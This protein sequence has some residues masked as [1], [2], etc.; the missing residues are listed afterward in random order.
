MSRITLRRGARRAALVLSILLP[1]APAVARK[2]RAA[3]LGAEGGAPTA[4]DCGGEAAFDSA[5]AGANGKVAFLR[6]GFDGGDGVY[7]MNAD[8]S[9]QLR[10]TADGEAPT[11]S[12]DGT[13]IAFTIY[14]GPGNGFGEIYVV[15]ADGC[16]PVNVTKHPLPDLSPTWS[17]D[18]AKIA[19]ITNRDHSNPQDPEDGLNE[20]YVMNA[21]GSNQTRITN[22]QGGF[23]LTPAWSPD[24][25]KIAFGFAPPN[26]RSDTEVEIYVI[27]ADSTNLTRLTNNTLSD[28]EPSWSPDSQK[29]AFERATG[30]AGSQ[31][32]YV[33]NADGTSQTRLTNNSD[34]DL[35]P[36]WSPDG[37]KIAFVG[38]RNSNFDIYVMNAGGTNP[39]RLTS[40]PG[41]DIQP[42]WQTLPSS[43]EPT[44]TP[45]P[46]TA[47]TGYVTLTFDELPTQPAKCVHIG[48]VSFDYQTNA[49]ASLNALY[50]SFTATT[51]F[52]QDRALEVDPTGTLTLNFDVPTSFLRFGI[53]VNTTEA[54][55]PGITVQLFDAASNPLGTFPVSVQPASGQNGA[56]MLSENQFT[57]SG[58]PV[59]RAVVT[60]ST[61][62]RPF[63]KPL[64]ALDNLTFDRS[65]AQKTSTVQFAQAVSPVGESSPSVSLNVTRAGDLSTATTISYA[66]LDLS[67]IIR[68]D[69]RVSFAL[70]RC[71]YATTVGTLFFAP[72]ESQKT[73]S[74]PLINDAHAE[75]SESF[76][77]QLNGATGDTALGAASRA[78]VTIQDNDSPG[79]PNPITSTDFSFFVRQQYLDFFG[80]E[81]DAGG[82]AA[83]KGTLDNCPDPFNSNPASPSANCDRV[84]VSTKF[85]RSREFELKG[86]YVFNFYKVSFG[87]LPHYS[88]IIPDMASLTA[89]DDAGFFARKAAFTDSFVQRQEFRNLYDALSNQQFVDALMGR[90]SLQQLTTP[91][92]ATPDNTADK[93]ML[94]RG[95]LV[96]RLNLGTLTRAQTL[97]AVAGSDEVGAAEANSS[98][99]AMQY[100]GYLRR[101]PEPQGYA[102]W[103]RTINA[104]PSDIRSMVNGF[105]NSDEYR[106]RFGHL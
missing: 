3:S 47:P 95:E 94:T 102:D 89:V 28:S 84:S 63:S 49:P 10:I 24:G 96:S 101:D 93:I 85:F 67:A 73:I 5:A 22:G 32:I 90:Y 59:S 2:S 34:A 8:G 45:A 21:D 33:M 82:F 39:T 25:T 81:P 23:Y 88:E 44:P 86:R 76:D 30:G 1:L 38:Y 16:N 71:D 9:N 69:E 18:G 83:W 19:F 99:V 60:G 11:F 54:L 68:C 42:A 65:T 43:P 105:M 7:V 58:A 31:E 40:D 80:R 62:G 41:I 64:F 75:D 55:S 14:Q 97:R 91:N 4:A 20:I 46:T 70:S 72:G 15:G 77:V 6:T 98:F 104:N 36:A 26:A 57:S 48:G 53:T 13:K 35:N 92:P 66:T 103:L 87:R 100:F 27:N 106:L 29:L 78:T 17:P 52:V 56:L 79:A 61:A 51:K 74:I 50:G 12:P 37:T